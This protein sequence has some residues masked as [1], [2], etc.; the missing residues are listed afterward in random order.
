ML[1]EGVNHRKGN[2]FLVESPMN[3]FAPHVEK[4]VVHPAHIPL[5]PEAEA[6]QVGWP[7]NTGPSCGFFRNGHD[8]G[9]PL[10]TDFVKA[11][12]EVNGVEIFTCSMDVWHPFTW[13]P[14]VVEIQH[15]RDRVYAQTIDMVAVQP[16]QTVGDQKIANFVSAVIKN[17]RSPV[18]MFA[19]ARISVFVKMGSVKQRQAVGILREMSGD[20]VDNDADPAFVATIDK[21]PKF[22]GVSKSAGRGEVAGN[23]VAP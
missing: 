14:R 15:R 13:F 3:R 8:P 4:E 7:G 5:Q 16:E 9:E 6:A 23:L 10:I 11:F 18:A 17:Q 2:F 22:V 12:H 1:V 19:L 21:V 20:P